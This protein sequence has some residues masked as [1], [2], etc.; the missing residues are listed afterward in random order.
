MQANVRKKVADH[1]VQ[2]PHH[3]VDTHV[4]GLFKDMAGRPR[5]NALGAIVPVGQDASLSS[6]VFAFVDELTGDR[7][8]IC[9][10]T[11]QGVGVALDVVFGFAIRIGFGA[12]LSLG[13]PT[14]AS[15]Q[16][17]DLLEFISSGVAGKERDFFSEDVAGSDA[18][19]S[20]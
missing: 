11:R 18:A 5:D 19:D 6:L 1:K 8:Q 7:G 20:L 17:R 2:E 13:P 9:S 16:A 4:G 15:L 3:D 14:A 10:I 12:G